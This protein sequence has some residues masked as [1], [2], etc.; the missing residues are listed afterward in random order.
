MLKTANCN[1]TWVASAL[2]GRVGAA[3]LVMLSVVLGGYGIEFSDE[4]QR[5]AYE[6]VGAILGSV[7]A[8]LALVSKWREARRESATCDEAAVGGEK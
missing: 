4:E 3:V 2:W 8:L 5:S 7:G 6:S 1:D